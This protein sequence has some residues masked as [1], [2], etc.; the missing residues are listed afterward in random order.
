MMHTAVKLL[1]DGADDG[2]LKLTSRSLKELR[3]AMKVFRPYRRERKVS[4]F[5][6]T[7]P[8]VSTG[9]GGISSSAINCYPAG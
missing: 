4:I 8:A 9:H 2:E 7:R 3:Y 1:R 6:S 5:G